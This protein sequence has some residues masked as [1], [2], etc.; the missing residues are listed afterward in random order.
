MANSIA[1]AKKYSALLDEIYTVGALT[2]D[3]DIPQELVRD[4]ANANEIVIPKL[5]VQGLATYSRNSGYVAGDATLTYE[6]VTF[7][8]ERGRKFTVD[9]QD[10]AET[11]GVA[12]GRLAGVFMKTKVTPEIDAYRFS[13][14]ASTSG[15]SEIGTPASLADGAAVVA[16]VRVATAKLDTDSVDRTGRILY[17][18][19]TLKGLV[20]D[21][22]TT[23]SREVFKRFD[24]IV[25]VPQSRFYKGITLA[26]SGDG[27][28]TKTTTTGR[29]INFMVIQKDAAIQ[30]NK[31]LVTKV[32]TPEENQDSDGWIF[33]FRVLGL[34]DV[35][36]N[37]VAGIYSH[38]KAS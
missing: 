20:D 21:L 7:D 5:T 26:A 33:V 16:A 1:L 19:S 12:F 23:K 17:I 38:I 10:D 11:I 25:E 37:K 24:K 29:D 27:G 13:K 22:D 2:T 36:D 28:Y 6:T 3:L 14:Y 15:I 30:F 8:Y 32:F 18:E 9:T 31:H 4:G 34:C 35:Y